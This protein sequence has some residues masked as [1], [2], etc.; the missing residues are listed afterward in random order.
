MANK[1]DT[2]KRISKVTYN[3]AEVPLP[4]TETAF[5]EGKK[6]EHDAFWDSY[7]QNGTRTDYQYAFAGKGWNNDT[8]KPKYDIVPTWGGG[9]SIFR[10]S[11]F[12]GN[13]NEHLNN[14]GVKLDFSK[15]SG[16][17]YLFAD[18]TKI[19]ELP[20]I[21]LSGIVSTNATYLFYNCTA[22]TT[23]TIKLSANVTAL[24]NSFTNCSSLANLTIEGVIPCAIDVSACPLT[25]DSIESIIN[26]LQDKAAIG[27]TGS[28]TFGSA[29]IAKLTADDQAA[30]ERK[31]W[32]YT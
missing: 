28:L 6:A 1:I 23:V 2:S 27:A 19:T 13:L 4:N 30:L 12:N 15:L 7:Q 17:A 29:N 21:D 9:T 25:H 8:F 5:E 11:E 26:A 10:V 32:S 18:C 22:L 3:G 24:T 31:G 16:A 20:Y 14:L